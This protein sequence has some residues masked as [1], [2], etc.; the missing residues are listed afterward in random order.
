MGPDGSQDFDVY[1][2]TAT[3]VDQEGWAQFGF[4]KMPDYRWGIFL[5][6]A[7]AG[8]YDPIAHRFNMPRGSV[9]VAV[10]RLGKRFRALVRAE[11]AETV[12]H[13]EAVESELRHL[14]Q[15]VSG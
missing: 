14:L 15:A 3:S 8:A 9:A 6:P 7:E 5:N 2:R 12:A 11:V 1:L 13:A 10:H 4:V